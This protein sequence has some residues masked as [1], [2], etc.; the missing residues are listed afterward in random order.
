MKRENVL[1]P[2]MIAELLEVIHN[3][4]L[5]IDSNHKIIF[6]NSRTAKMFKTASE[7]LLEKSFSTLFMPADVDILVE[8][9]LSV[10]RMNREIETEAMFLK[11][12]GSTFLGRISGTCFQ[13]AEHQ[14]GM[15]Y[16]IHDISD[17]KEIEKALKRSERIAFLGRLIDDISHQI[18]NP[19]MAIGGFARRLQSNHEMSG[20]VE[21]ILQEASRLEK[22]L[23]TINRFAKLPRPKTE[24]IRIGALLGE[25]ETVV[26]TK[27]QELGC[28]W[29]CFCSDPLLDEILLID[30]DLF[31]EAILDVAENSCEAYGR[32]SMWEEKSVKC[33]IIANE[34]DIYPLTF[35]ITD[36]GVGIAE[37]ARD[38]VFS[39]FY[40]DK[41]GHIGMGLTFAKRIIEE[42]G[43]QMTIDSKP[44]DGTTV[45][46]HLIKERRRSLRTKRIP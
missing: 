23:N 46:F 33:E 3:A 12:D 35:R 18:R 28:T 39:H 30:K 31:L 6:A 17:M 15:V 43:G 44:G 38:H 11:R 13:W 34:D 19:I 22:L 7:D 42:Q 36:L 1:V 25:L 32:P 9:I 21:I 16:S 2:A 4:L 37:H 10:T 40:T 41:T 45:N 5:V 20:N 14:E 24:K 27:V 29:S 8:N 26:G